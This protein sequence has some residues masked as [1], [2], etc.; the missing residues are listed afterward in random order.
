MAAEATHSIDI[1]AADEHFHPRSDHPHWNES[2]W[3]GVV[4]PER[5]TT[6]YVYFFHRPNMSL[7]A[8]GVKVWDPSGSSEYDCLGYD[9]NRHLALPAGA[10]MFDF[11]LDNGLSVEMVEPFGHFRIR[12]RGALDLDLEWHKLTRPFAFGQ[13]QGLDGWTTESEGFTNGH[14]Q[15][16]GRMTGTVIVG[17]ETIAVDQPSIRDRSWGPRDA[18]AARRMELV[19]CCASERNYFSVL[20]VSTQQPAEDPVLG[21]DDAVAFGYYCRDGESALVTGG[22]CRVSERGPDLSAR[23]AELHAI[24]DRGRMLDATG[25]NLN[26][27]VWPVYDRTYQLCAGMNWTFD[28]VSAGGEDWSCMPTEQ[29]RALLR[30]RGRRPE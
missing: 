5:R 6:I 20:S 24:D 21:V 25:T 27:L 26:T 23:R 14:Y 10:D 28:G 13:N 4:V 9:Y 22:T 29:A 1:D 16:Y 11:T 30:A 18:V 15:Q 17:G 8:G 2:A 3:F 12:H 19:W 7:S